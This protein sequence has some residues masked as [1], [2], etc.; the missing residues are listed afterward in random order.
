MEGEVRV[1]ASGFP[2]DWWSRVREGSSYYTGPIDG[3]GTAHRPLH[4]IQVRVGLGQIF[5]GVTDTQA[6][7][8]DFPVK[9]RHCTAQP[10]VWILFSGWETVTLEE[11]LSQCQ[12]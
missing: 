10:E 11:R 7:S 9:V 2:Q 5:A 12:G 3:Q 1:R 6:E 8:Q 4:L